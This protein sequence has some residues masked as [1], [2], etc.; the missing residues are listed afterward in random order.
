MKVDWMMARLA[1]LAAVVGLVLYA[2]D[3][4]PP[5]AQ[6]ES[7]EPVGNPSAPQ[8]GD[9]VR[10]DQVPRAAIGVQ[11][12]MESRF[13]ELDIDANGR[14]S[15]DEVRGDVGLRKRFE[16]L[17]GND[18]GQLNAREFALRTENGQ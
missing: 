18:D 1:A 7:P 16:S 13:G 2:R 5:D 4:S 10:P 3:P 8:A 17:D 15:E 9:E 6:T 11:T 14:L 12:D